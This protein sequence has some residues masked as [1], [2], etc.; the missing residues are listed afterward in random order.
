MSQ[1]QVNFEQQLK[2]KFEM[3][4]VTEAIA[5]VVWNFYHFI[6]GTNFLLFL[7]LLLIPAV[8]QLISF[9]GKKKLP[10]TREMASAEK[11]ESKTKYC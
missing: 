5:P 6:L 1:T 8:P 4:V 7:H 3:M 9:L 11:V 2:E 10:V